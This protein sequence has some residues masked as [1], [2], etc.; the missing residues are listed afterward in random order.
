ME[1]KLDEIKGAVVAVLTVLGSFLG[2]KGVMALVWV[3]AMG[4]D[5]LSGSAAACK[6]GKWS[7]AVARVGLWHKLGM[8]LAVLVSAFADIALEIAC[9]HIPI[10]LVWPG[11]IMPLVLAWY[12]LTELGSILENAV[13]LGAKVPKW[14]TKFLAAFE[15]LVDD[16]AD[17]VVEIGDAPTTDGLEAYIY[18]AEDQLNE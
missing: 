8:I 2:W 14:L 10:G 17:K 3:A 4:L 18:A 1:N 9:D 7:S 12:I 5:Y 16:A 15:H 6:E 13:R 11:V